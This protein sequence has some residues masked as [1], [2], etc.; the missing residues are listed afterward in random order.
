MALTARELAEVARQTAADRGLKVEVLDEDAMGE[1]GLGGLLAVNQ[2]SVEPPRLVKLT[3]TPR[4]PQATVALVGKG[5][6]YDSGGI[7]LKPSDAMHAVMKMDMSGAAAVLATMSLLP[8]LKPKVKVIGYL[9]CTDNMPSGSAFK[10][11]DVLTIRNGKTVEIHN[12]DAEGR[13]V[14]ADGLS[15]AAEEKPDA[16]LDIATLTGAVMGALGTKL[17]GVMGNDEAWIDQ[18]EAGGQAHRRAGV[19]AAAAVGVPQAARQR[20]GRHEERRWS[21]RRRPRGGPVPPGVRRR[22]PV[23][24]PRH[25]RRDAVGVRRGLAVQG[26]HRLRGAAPHRP[27]LRVQEARILTAQR[28]GQPVRPAGLI[29]RRAQAASSACQPRWACCSAGGSLATW[30]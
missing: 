17:A 19:A 3:Y 24:P 2:G 15:L 7:S 11:G 14:L 22:H 1:L 8:A 20:R 9:C 13:L 4:N 26:R 21:L 12:T 27:P 28:R 18:V 30:R 5:I 29:M 10:L 25:R 23:G 16:V 6:T